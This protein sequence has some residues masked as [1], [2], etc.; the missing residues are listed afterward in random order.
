MFQRD[1]VLLAPPLYL[2]SHRYFR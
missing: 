1:H 2:I